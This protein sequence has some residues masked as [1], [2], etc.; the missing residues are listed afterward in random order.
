MN[1]KNS[2]QP[3]NLGNAFLKGQ[4]DRVEQKNAEIDYFN[5]DNLK[6]TPGFRYYNNDDNLNYNPYIQV[7]YKTQSMFIPQKPIQT[8]H[9]EIGIND[10]FLRTY[11]G[12]TD[13]GNFNVANQSLPKKKINIF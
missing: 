3:I 13:Y 12:Y 1:A 9:D 6:L 11:Y 10:A 7:D 8:E 2:F 4:S 5:K